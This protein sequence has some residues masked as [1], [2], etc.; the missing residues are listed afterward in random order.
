MNPEY[1]ICQKCKIKE[2]CHPALNPV[3]IGRSGDRIPITDKH[4]HI[5][6]TWCGNYT[7]W[8]EGEAAAKEKLQHPELFKATIVTEFSGYVHEEL[9]VTFGT[10]EKR[11]DIL[12][13]R[14]IATS[15]QIYAYQDGTYYATQSI[16]G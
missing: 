7:C 4:K 3:I 11:T 9:T 8:T 13:H 1:P 5:I 14:V 12:E 16:S 6:P 15:G 10:S 2:T